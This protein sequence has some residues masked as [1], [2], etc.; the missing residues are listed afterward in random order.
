M[1]PNLNQLLYTHTETEEWHRTHPG[2]LSPRYNRVETTTIN[3]EEV[4]LFDWKETLDENPVGLIKESRFTDIPPHIN[5]DM[6]L[7]YVYDGVCT[8]IV[9]GRRLLLKKGDVLICNTGVV[10]SVP[11][12][13]GEHDIVISIVFKKEMFDSLFLSQ[14][15]GAS[16]LTNLLFDFVSKNREA[17]KYLILPE[18]YARHARRLIEMLFIE[19]HFK[20]AYSN[21]LMRHL[22]V[23]LFLVLIRGLYRRSATDNQPIMSDERI[24]SI[25]NHIERSYGDCTLE[26]IASD[27]GYSTSYLSSLIKQKTGKTFSQIKLNQQLTE[28][29]Y[30]L[31][32]T[33]RS[34]QYVARKV[35][36]SNM[37]FFYSK[38][39]EAFGETPGAFRTHRS[40]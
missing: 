25:L 33:E 3:G 37:S 1:D 30:L 8:F 31:N 4:Y 14:L 6:E 35:G 9:N 21:E 12:V 10:R 34:V 38:F 24:V 20:D 18:E 15:P 11:Y 16:P 26:S 40:N 2:E 28:A 32:N 36:I 5:R 23:S 19:Y 22:A 29:A 7:N 27:T 13:K 17:R 39:K